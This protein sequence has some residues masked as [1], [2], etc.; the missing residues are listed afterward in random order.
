MEVKNVMEKIVWDNID[1]VLAEV[2]DVC[3]CQTC[4]NDIAAYALNHLKPRYATTHKG[5][6]ITKAATLE[7]QQFLDVIA[8]LTMAVKQVGK[9]PRHV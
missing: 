7:T 3:R 5:E 1:R 8:A 6:V 9:N 4:R 2:P